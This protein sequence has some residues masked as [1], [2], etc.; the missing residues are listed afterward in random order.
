VFNDSI[1]GGYRTIVDNFKATFSHI[2]ERAKLDKIARD[3]GFFIRKSKITPTL[4]LDLLFY[5]IDSDLKSLDQISQNA[6]NT[7]SLIVSKQALDERFSSA[8]TAFIKA[9]IN[10]SITSQVYTSIDKTELQLFNTVRIKDSTTFEIHESLCDVFEGFGKGG[11][12]NS[13]AGVSIQYEFDVKNNSIFDIDLKPAIQKDSHDAIDKKETICKNDLIIRDLG[14]YSD[15]IIENFMDKKAFFISKLYHN[16]SVRHNSKDK[17]KIDFG[18]LYNQMIACEQ[19]HLDINVYIGKKKRPVRLIMVLMPEDI[20]QK[21]ITQKNKENKSTGYTISQEYKCRAHYNLYICNI[22]TSA[23]RWDTICNLY[24]M[25]WQIE[26]VFK[27][28]KSIMNIDLLRK[29]KGE[30]MKTTLYAKLLWIFINWKI[31]SDCRN[32]FYITHKQL[33]SIFKCFKTLKEKS[34]ELRANLLTSKR[35]LTKVLWK[36]ILL[37]NTK[38]WVEKRKRRTN[39]EEIFDLLFYKSE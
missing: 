8:S 27:T 28:W 21:R 30:R 31:I 24:R 6:Y 29:M 15:T 26:L 1:N 23:C 10:E 22:P 19:N 37:L 11:G 16:V 38:H 14:Y 2:F 36:F 13:K 18:H 25:R 34:S 32:N 39:F 17:G 9:L 7:H 12:R 4:F 33:L 20:Y 3:T 5:G 35:N